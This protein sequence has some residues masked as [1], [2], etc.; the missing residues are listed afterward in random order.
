MHVCVSCDFNNSTVNIWIIYC[1]SNHH[2]WILPIAPFNFSSKVWTYQST[3]LWRSPTFHDEGH[4]RQ[5]GANDGRRF[6]VNKQSCLHIRH[7]YFCSFIEFR[8][9]IELIA[10]PDRPK[11]GNG[12]AENVSRMAAICGLINKIKMTMLFNKRFIWNVRLDF[13]HSHLYQKHN[14]YF[15]KSNRK[16]NFSQSAHHLGTKSCFATF[17]NMHYSLFVP[18]AI[19]TYPI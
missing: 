10:K 17:C 16:A 15:F 18:Q 3:P 2:L 4:N 13:Y 14:L 5:N 12:T 11:K 9:K 19:F 7:A 8:V 1:I 6:D